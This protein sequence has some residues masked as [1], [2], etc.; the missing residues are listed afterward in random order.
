M[1]L[2][3]EV[4]PNRKRGYMLQIGICNICGKVAVITKDG[5]CTTCKVTGKGKEKERKSLKE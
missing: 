1:T 5:Y 4:D 3:K 2:Y